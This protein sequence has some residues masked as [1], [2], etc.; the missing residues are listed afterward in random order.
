MFRPLIIHAVALLPVLVLSVACRSSSDRPPRELVTV[1][2]LAGSWEGNGNKTIGF[3]SE[4]GCFRVNWKT[5][6]QH[7]AGPGPQSG[8]HGRPPRAGSE[9]P[10]PVGVVESGT[11]RLTV[12]S[13]ISG[14]PI[15]VI[16]D[17]QGAGSGTVDFKDDPR[18]YDFLVDSTNVDWAFTVEELFDIDTSRTSKP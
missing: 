14:R 16:A 4:T 9:R 10:I 5:R 18:M 11:F 1:A 3:V 6:H 2:R 17:H 7:P 15:Q 13:A 8:L 12:R